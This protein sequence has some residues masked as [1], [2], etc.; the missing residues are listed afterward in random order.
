MVEA[1]IASRA[2]ADVHATAAPTPQEAAE[3]EVAAL[4]DAPGTVLAT[5]F[6]QRLRA[7]E[8]LLLHE[9]GVV[10]VKG[11]P[12][13]ADAARTSTARACGIALG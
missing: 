6:Q 8:R 7:L 11:L 10:A 9:A 4:P 13:P 3:E 12:A 5:L 2:H 1:A